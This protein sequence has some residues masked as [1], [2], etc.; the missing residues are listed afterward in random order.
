MAEISRSARFVA[1]VLARGNEDT[2]F[3]ARLRRADNPSTEYQSWEILARFGIDLQRERER[4]PFAL[5]GAALCKA[6]PEIDGNAGLGGALA[7]CYL[8]DSDNPGEARLRRLLACSSLREA[9]QTLRPILTLIA[10]KATQ[11]L[12]Y[13]RL[14]DNLLYFDSAHN[15]DIKLRWA[16][17]FYDYGKRALPGSGAGGSE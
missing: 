15:R 12:C 3:A 2:G 1:H 13:G 11:K 7:S 4:L 6:K 8:G 10:G 5:I 14:L 16:K 17:D 9:C